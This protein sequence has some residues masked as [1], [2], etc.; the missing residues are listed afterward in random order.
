MPDASDDKTLS[1]APGET[2]FSCIGPYRLVQ[3]IGVGGMGEV[4]RAEQTAPFHRIVA[5]KLIKAGR[6]TRAALARFESERQALALM[7]HPN[8]AKLFDAGRRP[9]LR[10]GV[11]ARPADHQLLR[12]ASPHHTQSARV[13]HA[14]LRRSAARAPYNRVCRYLS[15]G[16][17]PVSPLERSRFAADAIACLKQATSEIRQ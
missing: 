5:L 11:C 4:W 15:G 14:G 8:I 13:V 3:R 6:D 10:H 2:S 12:Q 17:S 7:E 1:L 9:L 16:Q